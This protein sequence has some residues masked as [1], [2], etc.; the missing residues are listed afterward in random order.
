MSYCTPCPPCDT[1]FPLLCEPLEITTQA[2]RLVV[3]DSAACQKTIQAPANQ[4]VL[5]NDSSSNISWTNG[6]NNTILGKSTTGE[7]EFVTLNSQL[8]QGPINVGSQPI[9]TTGA[10]T[11]GTVTAGTVTAGTVTAG[12]IT[13]ASPIVLPSDPTTALQAATKQYVDNADALRVNK[14]GDTMTGTL[15]MNASIESN[16]TIFVNGN[17][18]KIGYNTGSG[19]TTTQGS[20][21]K[22]NQVILNRP[23]GY[24][25]TA[26]TS[27]AANTTIVF[28]LINT[29]IESTDIVI[30]SHISGG[31]IGS[32]NIVAQPSNGNANIYIRNITAAALAEALTLRFIVLKSVDA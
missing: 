8:Q 2:K 18:S 10:I 13:T 22:A 3:E 1:E 23:T 32:Y 24:I 31:S 19:G 9:T 26:N 25:V 21:S 5:K 17:A 20:T 11:A 28:N 7:V 29:V 12:T 30:V 15:T 6:V 14:G 16:S 4:Q 27:L